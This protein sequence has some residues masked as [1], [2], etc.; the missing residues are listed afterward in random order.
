LTLEGIEPLDG[1]EFHGAWVWVPGHVWNG[2]QIRAGY[3]SFAP[4][5]PLEEK[6]KELKSKLER[7]KDDK[8]VDPKTVAQA[9]T[10]LRELAG[11]RKP[12]TS[13]RFLRGTDRA[14]QASAIRC[15]V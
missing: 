5:A 11:Q 2:G 4:D 9:Q 3:R 6:E 8:K 1:V 14:R 12:Y 15:G 7:W 13:Q 10:E